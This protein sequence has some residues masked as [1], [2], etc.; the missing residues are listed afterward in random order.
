MRSFAVVL[1]L[2]GLATCQN[3]VPAQEPSPGNAAGTKSSDF[4]DKL[5]QLVDV[6]FDGKIGLD[7]VFTQPG[8]KFAKEV[9]RHDLNADGFVDQ[10]EMAAAWNVPPIPDRIALPVSQAKEIILASDEDGDGQLTEQELGDRALANQFGKRDQDRN[11]RLTLHELVAFFR[12]QPRQQRLPNAANRNP[13]SKPTPSIDVINW[14]PHFGE[15][16]RLLG[17]GKAAEAKPKFAAAATE[18]EKIPS[19][20]RTTADWGYL[21]QALFRAE[22]FEAA[23]GAIQKCNE[24]RGDKEPSSN[25]GP[26][27]WYLALALVKTGKEA[28][29][30]KIYTVLYDELKNDSSLRRNNDRYRL[31]LEEML[32]IESD[33]LPPLAA[34]QGPA[35]RGQR[36]DPD[37]EPVSDN[38]FFNA[39]NA[40]V[41]AI[42]Q[43]HRN[44]HTKDG[45]F[46]PFAEVLSAD[47][48]KVTAY[49]RQIDSQTLE[50]IDVLVIANALPQTM[51]GP[52][53]GSAFTDEE[54][55]ILERWIRE[56]GSLLLLAD[57]RPYGDAAGQLGEALGIE[58]S[59]GFVIEKGGQGG[60]IVFSS[61]NGRLANHPVTGGIGEGEPINSV[62]SFTGQA[63]RFSAE[64]TP[65]MTLGEDTVSVPD[66]RRN[67]AGRKP[68]DVSGWH[69]GGLAELGK[70]RV[71]VFGEA[72]MFSAQVAGPGMKMGMNV[73]GAEQNQQFLK[74]VIRWLAGDASAAQ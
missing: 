39:E 13:S 35:S 1:L 30:R 56:G 22:R 24:M 28:E 40:P 34:N 32:G 19:Y 33:T 18:L 12:R 43:G 65:I 68:K 42:D 10:K 5:L 55:R 2:A 21:G 36:N 64:F 23:I 66:R 8:S 72:G 61:E 45:R 17:E 73:E 67:A 46:R 54:I 59:S 71:A 41:V 29:A 60:R 25:F 31:E 11:Q 20:K 49:S 52:K 16:I 4:G 58:M 48:C 38:P 62:T 26:R 50:S 47:G 69:Q 7:E 57:H 74:N 37:F 53:V 14:R 63:L 44:F 70:G 3:L 9:K 51:R 27:W 6:N 15:G